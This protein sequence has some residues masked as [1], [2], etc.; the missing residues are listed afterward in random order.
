MSAASDKHGN[1]SFCPIVGY[2]NSDSERFCVSNM[3]EKV[4]MKKIS[5]VL[6]VL[7]MVSILCSCGAKPQPAPTAAPT[8]VPTETVVEPEADAAKE[9]APDPSDTHSIISYYSARGALMF[10]SYA[11]SQLDTTGKKTWAAPFAGIDEFR[12]PEA[13]LNAKGGIR[14]SGGMELDKGMVTMS[15]IYIAGTEADYDAFVEKM[16][17]LINDINTTGMTDEKHQQ[18]L[19]N[20]EEYNSTATTLFTVVGIPNGTG[21][22]EDKAVYQKYFEDHPDWYE[23]PE[24][25]MKAYLDGLV[26]HSAGSAE[27]YNFYLVQGNLPD[28]HNI[29]NAEEEY[30]AEYK[31]LYENI[32]EY[33]ALFKFMKP[34]GLE[35]T[36][37]SGTGIL[38]ETTD[39]FGNTV[40]SSD[41]FSGHKLTMFNIWETGCSACI[42]EM[43]ELILI[44]KELEAKNAQIVGLVYDA[45]DA[46]L[47]A[48]A[49]DI[50]EDLGL[51]YTNIVPNDSIFETFKVQSFPTTY[52]INEKGEI[53]GEPVLGA[54]IKLY[55]DKINQYLGE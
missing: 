36:V 50:V 21:E 46:E 37:E 55:R 49:K 51:T 33:P 3:K 28:D 11:F 23:Y 43:P 20:F 7:L 10:N 39:V 1:I 19:A 31:T 18:Y 53:I 8:D 47:T 44:N 48:E 6:F 42:S 41:L 40:K 38:F 30:R 29:D 9:E 52:F 2:N 14:A 35:E 27:G 5:F 15:V 54:A 32:D 17:K 24:E 16:G 13:F 45:E 12:V 26:F 4:N 22:A 34:M 25:E